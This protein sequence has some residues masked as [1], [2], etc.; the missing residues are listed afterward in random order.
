MKKYLL[1]IGIIITTLTLFAQ[2]G[3]Q[4]NGAVIKIGQGA[5]VK[6]TGSNAGYTN[7]EDGKI[8]SDGK[9]IIEGDWYNDS[10]GDP[11]FI[12]VNGI[13]E[14]LFNG[15][16]Q[17]YIEGTNYTLF[18][19]LTLNNSSGIK[20]GYNVM[21]DS[22]LSMTNTIVDVD[23]YYL[24]I[25]TADNLSG[26]FGTTNMIVTS[27]GGS[28][29][30]VPLINSFNEIPMGDNTGTAEYSKIY[31]KPYSATFGINPYVAVTVS[32]SKH[33]QNSSSTDFLNRYWTLSTNSITGL[34][35]Q[36]Y[37][38]YTTADITGDETNMDAGQYVNSF[39]K[40]GAYVNTSSNYIRFDNISELGDFT[41]GQKEAFDVKITI[42]N[43]T[44]INESSESGDSI[45]VTV[46]NGT[47]ISNLNISNWTVNNLPDGVS[48]SSVSRISSTTARIY[49]S[50]NRTTDYD[51]D[52]TDIEVIVDNSEIDNLSSGSVSANSGVV[53][54]ANNDSES[55]TMFDDGNITEGSESG[56]VITITLLGGT[57]PEILHTSDWEINN[58]PTGVSY[59]IV[60]ISPTVVHINLTSN[61]TVDYD[62]D[63]T[64]FEVIIPESDLDDHTTGALGMDSGVTFT[65]IVESFTV[66]MS[67]VNTPINEGA[68]NGEVIQVDISGDTFVASL[69]AANW[70]V[71]NLPEGVSK[72]S[73]SRIDN[74]TVQITLSG[75]R[76]IDYD[77]DITDVSVSIDGAEIT[78]YSNN[79]IVSSGVTLTANNDAETVSLSASTINEGSEDGTVV[80][81]NLSGGTFYSTLDKTKWEVSN[82]P[83]GVSIGSV[84]YVNANQAKITLS[85]NATVD[86]DNN[87]DFNLII[88][89]SQ[90]SDVSSDISITGQ[91]S[92]TATNDTESITLSG[93]ANEG[94]E[95]GSTITVTLTGG[96]FVTPVVD[97]QFVVTNLPTGVEVNSI[98]YQ[99]PTQV[100]ITLIGNASEDYDSDI[101]NTS[102]TIDELAFNDSD[103]DISANTGVTFTAI[104][105]QVEISLQAGVI[106]EE[107]E[108]GGILTVNLSEDIFASTITN[109]NCIVYNLPQGVSIGNYSRI[110]NTKLELTLSGNRT[111]DYDT[112]INS[113]YVEITSSGLQQHSYNIESDSIVITATDDPENIS[114]SDKTID[115]GNE[116]GQIIT[117]AL[118]GGTFTNSLTLANWVITNAPVGVTFGSLNRTDA[119]TVK[120]TL[121]GNAS[122]DYDTDITL[123]FTIGAQEID[124]YSGSPIEV[125]TGVTFKAV[126][127]PV[128]MT[129]ANNNGST[130]TEGSEDGAEILVTLQNDIFVSTLDIS[131]WTVSY[132]PFGVSLDTVMRQT[133][134]EAV[135]K[136]KGNSI[137]D[138]DS[139][140]D[141]VKVLINGSQFANQHI[142][143]SEN[144]G[145]VITAVNDEE[146]LTFTNITINEREENNTEIVVNLSGGTFVN[147]LDPA[148]WIISNQP[149]GVILGALTKNSNTQVTLTLSGN[150]DTDF[151][152]DI[153]SFS[154]T[155]DAE[156]VDEHAA[157]DGNLVVSGGVTFAAKVE[158]ITF[159][160]PNTPLT[161]DNVNESIINIA[162]VNDEFID[163]ALEPEN[164]I[165]NNP[166]QG[167][168]IGSV[169]Y[170][171]V[172]KV[173][174][175]L[176]YDRT[177]FDIDYDNLY[178]TVKA[179]ELSSGTD[180]ITPSFSV[181]AIVEMPYIVLSDNGITEGDE[182]LSYITVSLYEDEFNTTLNSAN[183]SVANLPRGI[184]VKEFN[185]IDSVTVNII[186][187]GNR[188]Q[189]YDEN[190]TNTSVE[191]SSLELVEGLSDVSASSGVVFI[192][193]NDDEA[194]SIVST[195][196]NEG[197]EDG[198]MITL[199]LSGGTF[200]PVLN[201]NN[202]S[203]SNTPVGV[204]VDTVIKVDSVT[205]YIVLKGNRTLD[206]DNNI[207][208]FGVSISSLDV[209]DIY[210]GNV[211]VN[212]GVT[213]VAKIESIIS[214]ITSVEEAEL[215]NKTIVLSLVDEVFADNT[216]EVNSFS[217]ENETISNLTIQSVSYINDTAVSL[218]LSYDNHDF[219]SNSSFNIKTNGSELS[220]STALTTDEIYVIADD[221]SEEITV[222]TDVDGVHENEEAG[223]IIS[224]TVS[225]GTFVSNIDTLNWIVSGLPEGVDYSIRYNNLH[226]V[227]IVLTSNTTVDYDNDTDNFSLVVPAN[228][229][230]DYSGEDFN[231][232]GN[233]IFFAYDEVLTLSYSQ[234]LKENNLSNVTLSLNLTDE[235]FIN[236]TLDVNNFT[237]YN[238]PVGLEIASVTYV[239]ETK[240]D[241]HFN[242]DNTD[243][244]E[245]FADFYV[246]IS[247]DE[248][249]GNSDLNSDSLTIYAI[250]ENETI[251][252]S[253]EGLNENNLN[254]AQV[255]ITVHNATFADATLNINNFTLN[256]AP[257]GCII[258]SIAYVND[259]VANIKF[260]F[261]GTDFDSD[262]NISFTVSASELSVTSSI[263]T[264]SVAIIAVNDNEVINLL[265]KNDITEEHEDGN[266]ITVTLD[267]GNFSQTLDFS[268][269]T[270]IDI[271]EGVTAASFTR[272]NDTAASFILS[273]NRTQDFDNDKYINVAIPASDIFDTD[274]AVTSSYGVKITA[275]NDAE[276]VTMTDD[277]EILE[278]HED[279]E[280]IIVTISGGTFASNFK[281]SGFEFTNFPTG[282]NIG[283]ITRNSSTQ[284]TLKLVG[285]RTQDYDEDIEA[286]LKINSENINDFNG[287][288]YIINS[289]VTLIAE[290]ELSDRTLSV[291]ASGIS[292]NN[293]NG[294]IL[295]ITIG[296][297]EFVDAIITTSSFILHNAPAGLTIASVSYLSGTQAN[298]TLSFD[299]TDFD[300]DITDFYIE[301]PANEL[302]SNANL[303]SDNITIEAVDEKPA[304]TISHPGL[305]ELNLNNAEISLSLEYDAFADATVLLSSITLN[306]APAG[307]TVGSFNYKSSTE[308]SIILNFDGTDF[309]TDILDFSVTIDASELDSTTTLT[310]NNLTIVAADEDAGS[311]IAS[312]STSLTEAALD[313]STVKLQLS[314]KTFVDNS[315]ALSSVKL[316]NYPQ[317]LTVENITYVNSTEASLTFDFTKQDFDS[318]FSNLQIQIDAV[319]LSGTDSLISNSL[320]IYADDDKEDITLSAPVEITE[321]AEDGKVINV[322]LS[323]GTFDES[324]FMLS[325]WELFN[326]PV[327]V[328]LD[329]VKILSLTT[330]EITLKGNTTTDYDENRE[331]YLQ[332]NNSQVHDIS[333]SYIYSSNTVIFTAINETPFATI[334]G[335]LTEEN[336]DGREINMHIE[337]AEFSSSNINIQDFSLTE[338]PVGVTI[339]NAEYLSLTSA[340]LTLSFNGYDFDTDRNI[341]IEVN[342]NVLTSNEN[343][344]SNELSISAFDDE[345]IFTMHDDG[346]IIEGSENGEIITLILNGGSFVEN[347]NILNFTFNNLPVGV[348]VNNYIRVSNTVLTFDLA[349][350]TAVDYDTNL[351]QFEIV[352]PDSEFD[353][354]N[355]SPVSVK[356]GVTFIAIA[357]DAKLTI[358]ADNGLNENNLNG[359]II[360]LKLKGENFADVTKSISGFTL[361]NAP[362]GLSVEDLNVI[363]YDSATITLGYTGDDFDTDYVDFN[364]TIDG[365]LLTSGDD[366]TSNVLSIYASVEPIISS[367]LYDG[368][369]EEGSEDGEIISVKLS[370]GK[371]NQ[372]ITN[373]D[374]N[375]SFLPEGVSISDINIS[376]DTSLIFKLSG[377]RTQDYDIDEDEINCIIS[378]SGFDSYYG[379]NIEVATDI[380][381]NAFDEQLTIEAGEINQGN[382]NGHQITMHL[383][384]D[385]FIDNQISTSS[386]ILHSAPAGTT[387]GNVEYVN[388]TTAILTLSFDGS[389]FTSNISDFAVEIDAVELFSIDNLMSNAV[390]IDASNFIYDKLE[391]VNVNIYA[392]KSTV[393]IKMENIFEAAQPKISIYDI[394]GKLVYY[395]DLLPVEKNKIELNVISGNYL[396]KININGKVFVNKVFIL[397][398]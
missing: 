20:L 111:V 242:F 210:N 79:V 147:T 390:E 17:Q 171:D 54:T 386:V 127:E 359:K 167:L 202:W 384:E 87:I 368:A 53:F 23:N 50:G 327:G 244:D 155:V 74:N 293:L 176:S 205:A 63:I 85:G 41:A 28:F 158:Q 40:K 380:V 145:V 365:S 132:L 300:A 59:N 72:G 38:Y 201:K 173:K 66:S 46:S 207:N 186:L 248:L 241:M 351:T 80:T 328:K 1:T 124:D 336:L 56:E 353:D 332:I 233:V 95:D 182:D 309:D 316:Y 345:E 89:K 374:I 342:N 313:N 190:I 356:G 14:V 231:Y 337:D 271:P 258:Q 71:N 329:T 192:A 68:E 375:L 47:F 333:D 2:S 91:L 348:I 335:Y 65:A 344:A 138:F 44:T 33:P 330:A 39:W 133:D 142:N 3:I 153:T 234:E 15:S 69:T 308:A 290:N 320:T 260:S 105:E 36:L 165:L 257:A 209:D 185:R 140:I 219:D 297:D 360:G 159:D 307:L 393:F 208:D 194:I 223:E 188:S 228:D 221:D 49:L 299:G 6:I 110:S 331:V 277:G 126:V 252:L 373:E 32:N 64:D 31:F 339:S 269:W 392:D 341:K 292:E 180:L 278:G 196:I 156:Q 211:S 195:E 35:A 255:T 55:F 304:L 160:I 179:A 366:L 121:S 312:V 83:E 129:I 187:Q 281:T 391:L 371:F 237:L 168:I 240:A 303:S 198:K 93:G 379:E 37:C 250:I 128:L 296:S 291:N 321:R 369:I 18:E 103:G 395:S 239:N 45:L 285:N 4:N 137:Y 282:I 245:D 34:N 24:Q 263:T 97:T 354:Y 243:F 90:L 232:S 388:D 215:N 75:N 19:N 117:V 12:N 60:R 288:A 11:V 170:I 246:T 235:K 178:I 199:E 251:S 193:I 150:A 350:N 77:A 58:L 217:I 136:L 151:D 122:E 396:V 265:S 347:I 134:T 51:T 61:T 378:T 253:D 120:I 301:I 377:N 286:I 88:D 166:P 86:Y 152:T 382:L 224:V 222:S 82:L 383:T 94:E 7:F 212:S 357:D 284:V 29:R 214:S 25:N 306:N 311:L 398:E 109:S 169:E 101:T 200:V 364:I 204:S 148:K 213:F 73:I 22:I 123:A 16:L 334:T 361:N 30:F 62:T 27:N 275:N 52:I 216:L 70:Q 276:T 236:T 268:N 130:I 367:I 247:S 322:S 220:G 355:G 363:S 57:F 262:Y 302:K 272:I 238:I 191:I 317:G 143:L 289:G 352:I 115:E 218:I 259:S 112:N 279:G 346:E 5:S 226:Q 385:Y 274:E 197:D 229:V 387:V 113:V 203:F 67:M 43:E 141:T 100:K 76:T 78:T 107:N 318:D 315:I 9:I 125:S 119:D 270:M 310:S 139:N 10:G 283:T 146:S 154:L 376:T 225:G 389:V 254:D 189:D 340:K 102:V 131:E 26:T 174:I 8:D 99:S 21:V 114:L 349:G 343:A 104:D 92:L 256:N 394:K 84:S 264:N 149:S 298:I 183:W 108:N 164:F 48:A 81:V 116:N 267:G 372:S 370:E 96:T 181:K 135:I 42:T 261:N 319:E 362:V 175:S 13:G 305:N 326:L 294:F 157:A 323:G 118:T 163:Y 161:E 106:T 249:R 144:N 184:S 381:F 273:G 98:S 227:D 295:E 287:D 314:G 230:D 206:Y 177:D 162:L 325:G 266:V 324:N 338:A 397:P 358:S 280:E 172:D